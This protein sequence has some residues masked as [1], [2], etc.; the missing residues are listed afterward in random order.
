MWFCCL[1]CVTTFS[2]CCCHIAWL[3]PCCPLDC[4]HLII[5]TGGLRLCSGKVVPEIPFYLPRRC[6]TKQKQSQDL[7]SITRSSNRMSM[8][9]ASGHASKDASQPHLQLASSSLTRL[10]IVACAGREQSRICWWGS[11][12]WAG[13]GW[14]RAW[15]EGQKLFPCKFQ[16]LTTVLLY[17][18]YITKFAA[19]NSWLLI[20]KLSYF[21]PVQF[22]KACN[23]NRQQDS[24]S[25]N[26]FMYNSLKLLF[27]LFYHF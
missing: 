13:R 7:P 6:E 1:T 21:L 3:K 24:V 4:E 27:D 12:G 17:S 16:C 8:P 23:P 25:T 14:M 10:L 11:G 15:G 19:K 26:E 18:P 22:I 5:S 20:S 2:W 9:P